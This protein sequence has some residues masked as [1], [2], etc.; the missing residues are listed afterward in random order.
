MTKTW[1][2]ALDATEFHLVLTQAALAAG[3][4]PPP[5]LD[6]VFP[7]VPLPAELAGRARALLEL[8]HELEA[9][10]TGRLERL[11]DRDQRHAGAP[12]PRPAPHRHL[13]RHRR[14]ARRRSG[15]PVSRPEPHGRYRGPE[16]AAAVAARSC[17]HE[18]GA[19][20]RSD[21]VRFGNR[22]EARA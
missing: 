19:A 7:N 6:P 11:R 17:L 20:C 5:P 18:P 2:E 9:I 12:G 22:P 21:L 10:A 4:Q 13:R 8:T 14:I 15:G 1:H 16:V 3:N